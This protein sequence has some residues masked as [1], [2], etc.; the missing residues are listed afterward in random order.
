[1]AENIVLW[2]AISYEG[3]YEE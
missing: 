1:M 2:F 3:L